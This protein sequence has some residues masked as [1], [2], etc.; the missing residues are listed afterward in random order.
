[1]SRQSLELAQPPRVLASAIGVALSAFS[2]HSMAQAVPAAS[3]PSQAPVAL[4]EVTVLG[5]Q[6]QAYKTDTSASKKYTAPLR[7]TPKS[8]TVITDQVIRDTGSL[9]LV[10]ALRTTSGITFGAGEGGN[11]AGDR[12]IIRGFNAE[13]DTFI[14]GL[15]DVGSQTREIFNVES[16]EVSK[17][18][19]S[20]YT[21]AGSTGGSLNLI[22]KTAKQRDFGDASVTLGSDQTRRYTLDINRVLG[23]NVAGRLNLMKHEANVAGRDGVDVSRW[24]VAP[25]ITFGFDTP[26]R[27]TLSYYHLETDDMPDYGIPLTVATP[28]NPGRKPVS[29]DRDNFYGLESRDFRESTTDAGTIRLEHDL[30]ESL[31]VSNTTRI[32]RTTLDYIVTNPDDSR[33]NVTNGLV[34]R[35]SKNRNSDTQSWVNQTDLTARFDTGSVEHT[36]VTGVEISDVG[37]HNRPYVV[38]PGT[39]GNTCSPAHLASGDCTSLSN[40]SPK[41]AWTGSIARSAATTDTDTETLAAYVFDTLKFNEQWSLNMGLRYDDYETEQKAVSTA[42]VVT[43]PENKSHFWNYQLGLVFN[44]LPNGSIYAAWSTS[45]NPSGETGGEG[46]DA[47]SANNEVLDPERNRNYEIGTKWDFFDE[48]LGLTAALFRTEKTNARVTNASGFQ[49]SIGETQVDGLELGATGQI[50]RNWQVFASYT[51]LDAELVKSGAANVG[52]RAAPVYVEGLYDGNEVPSTPKHS[53]SFWNTYNLTQDLTIGGGAT[54][55][56]SRFGDT[57]NNIEVPEYWRYDAMAAYRVSKNLD[58]QLNVQNLTDKRYFDQ[59][60]GSHYAHVAAGRTALLST[61]FHF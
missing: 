45:S 36:L 33:G 29:V 25:T 35:S 21:G 46:S 49:E 8:V 54:Y 44:P 57:A 51:Y 59:V 50:T 53:F 2:A 3:S 12:P 32:A 52:T 17:G 43:R 30:S 5:E 18:P 24:G 16:I 7:E 11:P 41:D 47:L 23:D 28:G 22:S 55:V 56:D 61:N 19:G 15:R 60:Y 27:A 58:L 9:T 20:A 1:M 26:T 48:R 40:P 4:D 34:S 38:T 14:D 10:D 31:T 6:E 13:S 39:S 37:V 42:G